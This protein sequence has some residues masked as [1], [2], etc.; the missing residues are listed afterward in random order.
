MSL[1]SECR[2]RERIGKGAFGKVFRGELLRA[3]VPT[4]VAVKMCDTD[5]E[6][7]REVAM[8]EVAL[9]RRAARHPNMVQLLG[10]HCTP[11]SVQV[12]L[13]LCECSLTDLV[14]ERRAPLPERSVRALLPSLLEAL[15][16]MHEEMNIVHR[17][18]KGGNVLVTRTGEVKLTDFNVSARLSTAKPACG[19][20]CG[21]PQWMAPEVIT[22]GSYGQSADVWSL[23]I[24]LLEVLEG[25]V[26][27]ASIDPMAAM[28]RIVTSPPPVLS[29]PAAFSAALSQ[30]LCVCLIK[31]AKG[32]PA[33]RQL[34]QHPLLKLE[35]ADPLARAHAL[36]NLVWERQERQREAAAAAAAPPSEAKLA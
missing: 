23:G 31:D 33:A 2:L 27:H 3:G 8:R 18:V 13:E 34:L 32:R 4:E 35:P 29:D 24:T 26:P 25:S 7:D 1:L 9:L 11:T 17:D 20:A 6:D 16:F 15:R 22:G 5:S 30:F 19:T 12:F 14:K 10:V 28:F 21:T 36:C